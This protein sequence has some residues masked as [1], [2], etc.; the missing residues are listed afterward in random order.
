MLV[1]KLKFKIFLKVIVILAILVS[2]YLFTG[3]EYGK[4]DRYK[5]QQRIETSSLNKIKAKINHFNT[6]T[7]DI[8]DALETWNFITSEVKEFKGLKLG[9]AKKLMNQLKS[10]HGLTNVDVKLS[11]PEILK[12][13]YTG[14]KVGVESTI[15][16]IKI[17]SYDDIQLYKFLYDVLVSLPG[18]PEII[19]LSIVKVHELNETNL[20]RIAKDP[21]FAPVV[22]SIDIKWHDLKSL[23]N[24]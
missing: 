14:V 24:D 11:K 3:K 20:Y 5:R 21:K 4:L 19:E 1:Q 8:A 7:D 12:G 13:A 6:K 23:T 2:C 15:L 18:Y 22:S 16:Q 10:K 17:R 9:D